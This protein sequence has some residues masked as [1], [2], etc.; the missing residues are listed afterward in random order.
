[1]V[2]DWQK[3][4]DVAAELDHLCREIARLDP[5]WYL[6]CRGLACSDAEDGTDDVWIRVDG[7][8]VSYDSAKFEGTLDAAAVIGP[9]WTDDTTIGGLLMKYLS[10]ST[11]E[12][13]LDL[14]GKQV[15]WLVSWSTNC[16]ESG[17][18][19]RGA[20]LRAIVAKLHTEGLNHAESLQ[21]HRRP[22][23]LR[24]PPRVAGAHGKAV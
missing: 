13:D 10:E 21:T 2:M 20:I 18:T 6:G 1:M 23:R 14:D 7:G 3:A 24:R 19:R 9:M 8:W 5:H 16:C 22:D 12:H 11:L 15:G 17:E 4:R